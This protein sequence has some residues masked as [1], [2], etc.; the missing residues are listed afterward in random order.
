MGGGLANITMHSFVK[1]K[2]LIKLEPRE[3]GE[4]GP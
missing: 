1:A 3:K 2:D 4:L